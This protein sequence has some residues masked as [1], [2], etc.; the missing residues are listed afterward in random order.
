M[1]E[2]VFGL[3][4]VVI[5]ALIT[6]GVDLILEHRREERA[7][8]TAGRML[9]LELVEARNLITTSLAEGHWLAEPLRVLSNEQWSEHRG[10]WAAAKGKC[11]DEVSEAFLKVADVRRHHASAKGGTPIKSSSRSQQTTE[12]AL[13]AISRALECLVS[14]AR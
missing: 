5:G 7:L 9:T 14:I 10:I 1:S 11:W 12:S 6:G 3:V 2:A 4:G 8:R 13:T